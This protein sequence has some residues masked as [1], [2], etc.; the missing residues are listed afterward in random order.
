MHAHRRH[1]RQQERKIGLTCRLQLS[2]FPRRHLRPWGNMGRGRRSEAG[3]TRRRAPRDAKDYAAAQQENIGAVAHAVSVLARPRAFFSPD[4]H[5]RHGASSG[6][7]RRRRQDQLPRLAVG[8]TGSKSLPTGE[9]NTRRRR[10]PRRRGR[11]PAGTPTTTNRIGLGRPNPT[12]GSSSTRSLTSTIARSTR[13][14][15]QGGV[16]GSAGM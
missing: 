1:A 12:A 7:L 9:H 11:T 8:A 3:A 10:S 15:S 16:R 5:R 13:A 6:H 4:R 14:G 2:P